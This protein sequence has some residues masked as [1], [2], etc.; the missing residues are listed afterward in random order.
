[1]LKG[2]MHSYV[3]TVAIVL[4]LLVGEEQ[5]CKSAIA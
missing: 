5:A 3:A 2:T 1:M 4:F